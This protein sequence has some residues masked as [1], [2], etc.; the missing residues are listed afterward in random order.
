TASRRFGE[1]GIVREI[2]SVGGAQTVQLSASASRSYGTGSFQIGYTWTDGREIVGPVTAPGGAAASAGLDALHAETV[3]APYTPHHLLFASWEWRRSSR[4]AAGFVARLSS[5][6]PFTPMVRGDV[7]A[8]GLAND[9]AF[10]FAPGDGLPGPAGE[11]ATLL[12]DAPNRI[13]NCLSAQMGQV[14]APYSCRSPWWLSL[15]LRARM[16]VGPRLPR[17]ISRRVTLWVV[18]RNVTAALDGLVHGE[19]RLRG[20]G[21]PAAT[22]NTLLVL[23]GFDPAAREFRYSVNSQ[24]GQVPAAAVLQRSPFALSIQARIVLGRDR[25]ETAFQR[26]IDA[27]SDREQAYLPENLR[28]HFER[29]I[30][31]TAAAILALNG[32]RRLALTPDQVERL[33]QVADSISRPRANLLEALVQHVSSA[34]TQE[35]DSSGLEDLGREAVAL[36]KAQVTTAHAV[37]SEQQWRKLPRELRSDDAQFALFPPERITSPAEY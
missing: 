17:S 19:D 15:D 27:G 5:G 16:Q 30:P 31:N 14:A 12:A 36:R 32:L 8:D 11:M 2:M 6:A 25:V 24:F 22:D 35:G 21:Q 26:V 10:V 9:R 18:A 7:N 28:A 34:H 37:L 20:W 23:D 4:L 29:Q 3:A 33:Q 1:I 13:R